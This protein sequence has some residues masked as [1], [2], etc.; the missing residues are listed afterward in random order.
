MPSSGVLPRD[1][2]ADAAD[3]L[4]RDG[5][6]PGRPVRGGDLLVAL[7]ADEHD[8]VAGHDLPL[9]GIN[10]GRLGFLTDVMPDAML[11]SVD[12]ALDGHCSVDTRAL[13]AAEFVAPGGERKRGLA[14]NDVVVQ[15]RQSGHLVDFETWMKMDME[16][17]DNWSLALDW[18]IILRTIPAVLGGRGAH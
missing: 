2:R 3:D 11:A 13:L 12:A 8:L 14:L 15:K 4:I 9:L 6:E 1:A 17:I 7:T 16:Y 5:A 10:R 18:K